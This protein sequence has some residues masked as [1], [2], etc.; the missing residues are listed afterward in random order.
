[1][2]LKQIFGIRDYVINFAIITRL[3]SLNLISKFDV[4]KGSKCH[5]CVE[6]KQSCKPHKAAVARELAPLDLI[7]SDVCEMNGE[8]T[9]SGKRYFI[10]FIED[11]YVYLLKTKDV[12]LHYFKIYKAEV[13]NQLEKKIKRL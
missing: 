3:A 10:T 5:V 9:K 4:V 1:M 7:H 11:C 12:T 8:L 13:E 2:M 6:A